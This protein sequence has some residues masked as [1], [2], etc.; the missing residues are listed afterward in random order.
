[1][2]EERPPSPRRTCTGCGF[3]AAADSDDWETADHPSLGTLTRCPECG[4]TDVHSR[5]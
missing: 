3:E 5:G 1:M 4:S 2:S